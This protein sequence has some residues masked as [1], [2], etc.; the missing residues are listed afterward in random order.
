MRKRIVLGVVVVVTAAVVAGYASGFFHGFAVA[1]DESRRAVQEGHQGLPSCD[2]ESGL[3]NAKAVVNSIP[4]LKQFGVI[5]LGISNAKSSSTSNDKVECDG[6][7]ILSNAMKG[8]V[9][10]SFAKD[11]SVDAPFLV[12]AN[13]DTDHLEK[14]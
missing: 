10:Y 7:V 12:R 3:A 11:S 2:T 5:A 14:F 1:F 4:A 13:I 6:T 9:H 8:P